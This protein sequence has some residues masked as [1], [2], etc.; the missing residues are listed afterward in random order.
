MFLQDKYCREINHEIKKN[1]NIR[2]IKIIQRLN[3][4]FLIQI[5]INVIEIMNKGLVYKKP[6]YTS[7]L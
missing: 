3:A 2:Y 7:L 6:K 5:F 1:K 4:I